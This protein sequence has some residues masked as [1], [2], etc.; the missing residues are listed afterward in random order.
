MKTKDTL[1]NALIGRYRVLRRLGQGGMGM[2]YLANVEGPAGFEKLVALKVVH[3]HVAHDAQVIE[4][5][6][7]EARLS[8]QLSHA[9]IAQI[10]DLGESDGLYYL[11]ME[12]VRG[13]DLRALLRAVDEREGR[14][15]LPLCVF[16]AS[17]LAEALEH[18][19]GLRD[20]AGAPLKLVHRDVTPVNCLLGYSGEVKLIDFGIAKAANIA[21]STRAGMIRG[22]LAYMSPEQTRGHALDRR[23]DVFALGVILYELLIGARP[24]DL[25]DDNEMKMI[26][27]IRTGEHPRAAELDPD[28]P[29][30]LDRIVEKALA[31]DRDQRYQSADAMHEDLQRFLIAQ[32]LHVAAKDLGAFLV[33]MVGVEAARDDGAAPAELTAQTSLKRTAEGKSELRARVITQP[34][35]DQVVSDQGPT[36]DHVSSKDDVSTKASAKQAGPTE[37]DLR[38]IVETH[39]DIGAVLSTQRVASVSSERPRRSNPATPT[40]SGRGAAARAT[41][42]ALDAPTENVP[43]STVREVVA[44]RAKTQPGKPELASVTAITP[45]ASMVPTE[46]VPEELVRR[47][48]ERMA[49]ER[50][51][52]RRPLLVGLTL[53]VLALLAAAA[54]WFTREQPLAEPA[55]TEPVPVVERKVEPTP[56]VEEKEPAPVAEEVDAGAAEVAEAEVVATPVEAPDAGA[57]A[58]V[59]AKAKLA[60]RVEPKKVTAT[61][62]AKDAEEPPKPKL[63]LITAFVT[64]RANHP[65]EVFVDGKLIGETP[66]LRSP[67]SPGKHTLRVDCVYPWGRQPGK[68][69]ELDLPAWAEAEVEHQCVETKPP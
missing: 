51:K 28:I 65:S 30:E 60:K 1:E 27:R 33:E 9:N 46:G 20:R 44:S 25:Q 34:D 23:S 55:P 8:A 36:K 37:S 68:L 45:G 66:R 13:R 11:A 6:L 12:Y 2:V 52:S 47:A 62:P 67:I 48:T 7:S 21:S 54:W 26:D 49:V 4:M 32:Q 40:V 43:P 19:H 5:F 53:A 3:T 41:P 17:K 63:P 22:K 24:F 58:Q 39:Q 29:P 56:V 16:I 35:R 14:I 69:K 61:K 50:R 15:P 18:A 38:P 42:L 31:V 64:V 57:V 59:E 10:Y